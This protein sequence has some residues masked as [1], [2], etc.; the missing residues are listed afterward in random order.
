MGRRAVSS[1]RGASR[2]WVAACAMCV[3]GSAAAERVPIGRHAELRAGSGHGRAYSTWRGDARRTGRSRARAP[4]EAPSRLWST[5]LPQRRLVPPLLLDSGVLVVGGSLGL[6]GLDARTGERL[7]FAAIG[8]V[9]HT[10]S[11]S[12]EGDLIASAGG[13]LF[14]VRRDGHARAVALPF[15]AGDPTLVLESGEIVL[16]D[17][18]GGV[19]AV[20]ADGTHLG[21]A[22]APG[23]QWTALVSEDRLVAAGGRSLTLLSPQDGAARTV[24]LPE[25]LAANPVTGGDELLW[26]I[27]ERGAIWHVAPGGELRAVAQLGH[28][29]FAGAP[30]L[31]WDGALRAALQHG[32]IVCIEPNGHERWRRGVDSWPGP[33]L[34]DA[35]DTTLTVTV[36]G[37]LYAVDRHGE[38]RWRASLGNFGKV[39]LGNDGTIFVAARGGVVE[40]WR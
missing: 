36:R 7:W 9:R 33:L 13:R 34:V 5:A 22:P 27:G 2:L 38:M 18:A 4:A 10:P 25:S 14:V 37:T 16:T 6:T 40:A 28:S 39:V 8:A 17:R 19:H 21:S 24:E 32:E 23:R 3:A 20:A 1:S 35:D 31:G 12:P 11:L 29:G 30:A 26:V 15:S